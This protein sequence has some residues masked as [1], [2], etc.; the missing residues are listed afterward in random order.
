M[1][2][3]VQNYI[4]NQ[5]DT[6]FDEFYTQY[7]MDVQD[8]FLELE[9]QHM[10]SRNILTPLKMMHIISVQSEIGSENNDKF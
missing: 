7:I 2:K 10:S 9:I 3:T 5:N 6:S 4:Q 8:Q 1:L